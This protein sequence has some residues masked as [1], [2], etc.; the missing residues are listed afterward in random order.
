L[1]IH[2]LHIEHVVLLALYTALT[3]ANSWL[4]KGVKGIHWFSLYNLFALLGAIAVSLRGHIPDFLSIV[5]GNLFVV[6]G[7]SLL[8]LSVADFFGR[9]TYHLY[10]QASLVLVA[11]VPM[12]QY[13]WIHPD[14]KLRLIAYSMVLGCQQAHIA[15]FLSRKLD[16]PVRIAT[17]SMALML[18]AL[19]L[20]NLVR[21]VGISLQGVPHN[22]LNAGSFLA[23]ILIINSCLQCGAMVTYVWMTAASLRHELE[24]QASTDPL[25]GLLNRRA[26]ELAAD[27]QIAASKKANA[28]ISAI[29]LDLDDFKLINDSFGHHCGDATLIAVASCLKRGM[30]KHDLLARIGGDEFAILLPHTSREES[31]E[32]AERL[33]SSIDKTDIFYGEVQTKVAASFGLAQLQEPA[34]NWED[35]FMNCD[36][37]LYEMKRAGVKLATPKPARSSTLTLLPLLPN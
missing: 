13:G 32:I 5:V 25:T 4:Y 23:W 18:S 33:R 8:F 20:A 14:T 26:I 30:R 9:K 3:V 29:V 16:G 17:A 34:N 27:R 7:Y 6:A 28:P 11:I 35:L 21:I 10:L 36:K 37:A 22:Y 31:A 19:S 24:V 12:L 1:D 2:T 15:I